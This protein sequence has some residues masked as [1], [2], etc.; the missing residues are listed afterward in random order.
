MIVPRKIQSDTL[1]RF[2]SDPQRDTVEVLGI[3][4]SQSWGRG[5][6]AWGGKGIWGNQTKILSSEHFT[7]M[8]RFSLHPKETELEIMGKG[9]QKLPECHTQQQGPGTLPRG[10]GCNN[11]HLAFKRNYLSSGA[12]LSEGLLR[13]HIEQYP[14]G[15]S[16]LGELESRTSDVFQSAI[17][18]L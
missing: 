16:A 14:L 8:F 9:G 18:P 6:R 5:K 15:T 4:D 10:T 3:K 2:E 7:G 13:C 12:C 11:L 17:S 1:I